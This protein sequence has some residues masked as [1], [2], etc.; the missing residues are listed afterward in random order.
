M[1]QAFVVCGTPDEARKRIEPAW[2][3]VDSLTLAP[4]A[5]G[6]DAGKVLAYAGAIAQTFYGQ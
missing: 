6:L 2:E 3:H 5:Y 4:P 1:A